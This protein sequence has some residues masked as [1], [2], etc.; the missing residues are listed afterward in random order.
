MGGF[1]GSYHILGYI[2]GEHKFSTKLLHHY[3]YGFFAGS[4]GQKIENR[5]KS[6]NTDVAI[7]HGRVSAQILILVA[8]NS[9]NLALNIPGV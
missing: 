1:G 5:R 8:L 9:T 2:F 3:I 7:S 6:P 4:K